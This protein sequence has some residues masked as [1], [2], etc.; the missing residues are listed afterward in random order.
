MHYKAEVWVKSPQEI[1][2]QLTE[3]LKPYK[4]EAEQQYLEWVDCQKECE[5][6]YKNDSVKEFYCNSSS[7]WGKKVSEENYRLLCAGMS[8]DKF[9]FNVS[10]GFGYFKLNETYK[11]YWNNKH[12]YPEG[13]HVWIRVIQIIATDHPDEDICFK[14][15]VRVEIIHPPKKIKCK[16]YY[17]DLETYI[18]EH[19]RYAKN[20]KTNTYGYYSNPN[21]FWDWWQTGGRY[22]GAKFPD[23]DPVKDKRNHEACRI[24]GGTGYR[25]DCEEMKKTQPLYTCNNCGEVDENYKYT[26]G[27]T[28]SKGVTTKFPGWNHLDVNILHV[29]DIGAD[30]TCY[31]AIYKDNVY[32]QEIW[33]N[34][35]W[36]NTD[37]NGNL[38]EI[39]KKHDIKT[40]YFVTVDYH[41]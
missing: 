13:L 12:E 31:T 26:G 39:I 30:A 10:D 32:H 1:E 40:G 41:S 3:I 5:D 4:E 25:K 21:S 2:K 6:G 15:K 11:C 33:N 28:I 24:C 7:S 8:G 18:K 37:W 9:V 17:K 38:L 23:Y 35:E 20:E 14:G 34:E 22:S 19:H 16:D 29:S 27:W 36:I